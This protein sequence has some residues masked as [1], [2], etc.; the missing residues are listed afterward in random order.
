MRIDERV[1][2]WMGWGM[3]CESRERVRQKVKQ[4]SL[5]KEKLQSRRKVLSL[6]VA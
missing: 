1:G 4:G 2:W 3:G 5:Q 6:S